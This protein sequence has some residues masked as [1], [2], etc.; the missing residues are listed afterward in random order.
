MFNML[1]R[2]NPETGEL[3]ALTFPP[4][5]SI[6]EPVHIVSAQPGHGGWLVLIVDHQT[7]ENDFTHAAWVVAADDISAGPVAK[8]RIPHRLR[9]QV[10]GWWVGAEAL[11][12][13]A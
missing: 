4:A 13:A 1:F 3:D 12:Q 9:P 11:A 7:G 8:V 10:H 6:S 2:I 5:H